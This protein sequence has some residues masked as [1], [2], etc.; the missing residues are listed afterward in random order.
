[1]VATSKRPQVHGAHVPDWPTERFRVHH[2]T[3][4]LPARPA[5]TLC[6]GAMIHPFL[7]SVS[8][9]EQVPDKT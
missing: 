1:M 3:V 8:A 2:W 6:K 5:F 4:D 9:R 7:E